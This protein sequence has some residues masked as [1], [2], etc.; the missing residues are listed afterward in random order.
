LKCE[1]FPGAYRI[2]YSDFVARAYCEAKGYEVYTLP[3]DRYTFRVC[4]DM[5]DGNYVI[6]EKEYPKDESRY[7]IYETYRALGAKL[8]KKEEDE[9]KNRNQG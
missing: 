7:A 8:F 2:T 3:V 6:R 1:V 4:I 9:R 5:P